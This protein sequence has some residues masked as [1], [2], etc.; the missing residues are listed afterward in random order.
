MNEYGIEPTNLT[1][2]LGYNYRIRLPILEKINLN[3]ESQVA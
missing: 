1:S 3:I 2:P